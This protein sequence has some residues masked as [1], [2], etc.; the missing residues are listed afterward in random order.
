VNSREHPFV[1]HPH[2]TL[3]GLSIPV[4]LSLTVEPMAGLVDTAFVERIGASYAAALAA[5]TAIYAGTIWV[6]NFLGVGTQTQIAQALGRGDRSAARAT[7]TLATVLSLILGSALAVMIWPALGVAA[8][9]MTEDTVVQSATV[10]YLKIRLLGAPALLIVLSSL[11][12]LRGLRMMP[13]TLWIA[14]GI[15]LCNI[16]LD[17][18]LIFGLGPIPTLGIAG[19]AWA[20]TGSQV[21]GAGIALLLLRGRLGFSHTVFWYRAGVLLSVGRD[22]FVR[23]GA[24]LLFLLMTTRTAVHVGVDAGAAH[25]ATRQV[26]MMMAFLLDAFAYAAQSLIGFFLGAGQIMLARR[27]ARIACAWG[28]GTGMT[29]TVLLLILE[30]AIATLLVPP[31]A[32]HLFHG[33]W[34]ACAIAQPLNSL[35]FVTDGIHWGT[36]DFAYLRN[37]MLVATT[38]GLAP[39]VLIEQSS[40]AALTQIWWITAGWI[41]LR[42]SFGLL[43]IWPGMAGSPLRTAHEVPS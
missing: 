29:L 4:M 32:R 16:I 5:A 31:T 9:W 34:V 3:I 30:S 13:T 24:L 8:R 1:S 20:T 42:A 18:I 39:L 22:M 27:V 14:G 17:P 7:T 6:F 2:K 38:I 28:F 12:A 37:A 19:A 33:A 26:W 35:S 15:S 36:G 40:P 23:T 25:Q 21:L 41:A 10:T 11:G 43:R